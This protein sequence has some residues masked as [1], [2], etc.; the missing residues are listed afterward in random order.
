MSATHYVTQLLVQ[1][2]NGDKEAL[3]DLT[4]LVYKELRRLAASHLRR[5][6][7]SHTLQPTALVHE[8]Y[9]RLVDQQNPDWQSRSHF[10]GVAARL[11]RQILVDHAR[12]RQ[13]GKRAVIEVSLDEAVS[14]DKQRAGNLLALD[15][16]L[17]LLEK[18]DPRKC[19]AVELRYFGGLSMDEIAATLEV[20]AVT[21]RR[22]LRMAEAWL[23]RDMQSE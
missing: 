19:R 11:M 23:H 15:A 8:A 16:S 12:R 17:D 21:V 5:E 9:L 1:W 6:R 18:M 4:P 10:F 13:A 22:D 7:K 2:A 3:D 20:S 14:F